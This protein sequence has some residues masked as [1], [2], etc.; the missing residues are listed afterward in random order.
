MIQNHKADTLFFTEKRRYPLRPIL[1][2]KNEA[3]DT[4]N[5]SVEPGT[6]IDIQTQEEYTVLQKREFFK[7][8][9]GQSLLIVADVDFPKRIESGDIITYV[10]KE[11]N[12]ETEENE[13]LEKEQKPT[14]TYKVYVKRYRLSGFSIV[15]SDSNEGI[16]NSFLL[17]SYTD[18]E[19]SPFL[20]TFEEDFMTPYH[21]LYV[22]A[23]LLYTNGVIFSKEGEELFLPELEEDEEIGLLSYFF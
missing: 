13:S 16:N 17:C 10:S 7:L 1:I 19:T 21:Q 3:N 11:D 14:S 22:A 5:I 4:L 23:S 8:K 15:V 2:N 18:S 12:E 9:K 20:E 6:I